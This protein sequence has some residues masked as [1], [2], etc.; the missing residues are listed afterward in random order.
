MKKILL[1]T[2][3]LGVFLF[4]TAAFANES[5]APFD[6]Q[7]VRAYL[8]KMFGKVNKQIND[9][10]KE[11]ANIPA[12]PQGPVGPQGPQGEPGLPAQHGA[13]NI[14]FIARSG[15]QTVLKT[16]GTTWFWSNNWIQN[17]TA[18]VPIPVSDIVSFVGEY[19]LDK[20]GDVWV[21]SNGNNWINA[22]HP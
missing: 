6:L 2:A 5:G 9:L 22:G 8:G 18:S 19:F 21:L 3:V 15:N 1:I 14:A 12:G 20:Y 7:D 16:D 13:G 17:N 11:I 4:T 10:H